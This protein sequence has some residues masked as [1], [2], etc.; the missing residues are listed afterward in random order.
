[1]TEEIEIQE[2][3]SKGMRFYYGLLGVVFVISNTIALVLIVIVLCT[4]I[5]LQIH[6]LFYW[7]GVG[8]LHLFTY[9]KFSSANLKN[10]YV[11]LLVSSAVLI[12]VIL[13]A[14]FVTQI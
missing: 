1:M 2:P 13:M 14:I 6:R 7:I 12:I 5:G 8:L 4:L 11:M 10:K 3:L 9:P